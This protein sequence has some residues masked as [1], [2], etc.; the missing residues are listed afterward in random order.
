MMSGARH[1]AICGN[2]RRF[3]KPPQ[4]LSLDQRV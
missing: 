2:A 4:R 3:V 1:A